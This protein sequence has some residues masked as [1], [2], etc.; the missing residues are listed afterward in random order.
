MRMVDLLFIGKVLAFNPI[1]LR[2]KL[3]S[4][5]AVLSV[6]GLTHQKSRQEN[7]SQQNYK[8]QCFV[9]AVS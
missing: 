4:V 7:L 1:T 2:P 9:Q 6:I 5:L 3:H 8:K